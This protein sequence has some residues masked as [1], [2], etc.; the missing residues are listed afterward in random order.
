M[1]NTE[2]IEK[3]EPIAYQYYKSQIGKK[4][5]DDIQV[6]TTKKLLVSELESLLVNKPYRI[7]DI[8]AGPIT[9]LGNILSD[10]STIE[11]I[12]ID[13]LAK[14]YNKLLQEY[15]YST[16]VQTVF[17]LG[18]WIDV[19]F[20]GLR[21]DI[22]Y[23]HNAID[24]ACNCPDKIFTNAAKILKP[25]GSIYFEFYEDEGER[26]SYK[27]MHQWNFYL[28]G[29]DLILWGKTIF[30]NNQINITNLLR[31]EGCAQFKHEILPKQMIRFIATKGAKK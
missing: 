22:V 23:S 13:P 10:G 5:F 19:Q 14:C 31:T 4:Q 6:R 12:A 16:P 21:F 29:N 7:L 26:S 11:I 18:E 20:N 24:H 30:K 25:N 8:G 2:W 3:F 1:N 28:D 15:N 27:E 9:T 17:G